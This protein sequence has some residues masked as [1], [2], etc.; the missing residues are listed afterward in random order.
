MCHKNAYNNIKQGE[1]TMLYNEMTQLK[2]KV[3]LF[4]MILETAIILAGFFM[5][6]VLEFHVNNI[7]LLVVSLTLVNLTRYILRYKHLKKRVIGT[8]V[9]FTDPSHIMPYPDKFTSN[10]EVISDVVKSYW[11]KKYQIPAHFVEFK[12]G[13]KVYLYKKLCE[14]EIGS[15]FTVVDIHEFSYALIEDQDRKKKI[16]HL[17]QLSKA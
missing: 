2:K 9:I 5:Y 14:E 15:I 8:K 6:F 11:Y 1:R 4:F 16:A 13:R 17:K 3:F 12:E 7:L 10:T